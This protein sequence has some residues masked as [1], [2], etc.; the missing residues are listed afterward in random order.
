MIRAADLRGHIGLSPFTRRRLAGEHDPVPGPTATRESRAA[1]TIRRL[2]SMGW[3]S[4][5]WFLSTDCALPPRILARRRAPAYLRVANRRADTACLRIPRGQTRNHSWHSLRWT[6]H[7][8]A[9]QGARIGM[10]RS[11][12]DRGGRPRDARE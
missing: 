7:L 2:Q 8:Y 10:A 5:I 6:E 12:V 4:N 9:Y 3:F 1:L 11:D